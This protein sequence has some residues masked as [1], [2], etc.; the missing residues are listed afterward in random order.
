MDASN[1]QP[2]TGV[3]IDSHHRLR[4]GSLGTWQLAGLSL[5]NMAPAYSLYTTL[6]LVVA[7]IGFGAPMLFL[8]A[9]IATFFLSNTTAEF[10]SKCPSAGSYTCFISRS[11]GNYVGITTGVMYLFA[12]TLL[13]ASVFLVVGTWTRVTISEITG[14]HLN[15]LWIMLVLVAVCTWLCV[16]GVDLS[17]R[18]AISLFAFEVVVL[19]GAS[20]AM[21]V[22][23]PGDISLGPFSVTRLFDNFKGVGL[24]FP[25]AVYPFIGS[26]NAAAMAEEAHKP[27][28]TIRIAVFAATLMATA[29]YVFCVY[30]TIVGSGF[31][32]KLLTSG[33]Y[34]LINIASHVMGPYVGILYIAG[35]TSTLSLVIVAINAAAR[36]LYN[37]SKEG[38]LPQYI[39]DVHQ[40]YNTPHTSLI[41]IAGLATAIG[42]I[43]G[44]IYGPITAFNW[45]GT[46]GTI[47]LI[48]IF[49]LVNLG[50]PVYFYRNY[51]ESFS[52]IF[53]FVF[54]VAGSLIYL[55]PLYATV[56]PGQPVP[57]NYFGIATLAV[58]IVGLLYAKFLLTARAETLNLGLHV[59]QED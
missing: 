36:V 55:V 29:I 57:Y 48:L 11:F 14:I 44:V 51:R 21:L 53:H 35:L 24:A 59:A 15:W 54:P 25:L 42:A 20:I 37:L 6:G 45:V 19:V 32:Q 4:K 13:I 7:G 16:I 28:T 23:H 50:L 26:N 2:V 58:V 9:G 12:W 39:S 52:P 17:S 33:T 18:V 49:V 30:A 3:N 43:L 40:R 22:A 41:T 31:D 47:P 10:S 27:H 1:E 34:P 46:L 5:A 38:V 56:E 8:L